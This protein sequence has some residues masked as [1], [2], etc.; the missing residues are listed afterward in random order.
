MHNSPPFGK[1]CLQKMSMGI[2][3]TPDMFQSIMME[4]LGNLEY[5][6]IYID[7]VLILKKEGETEENHLEKIETVLS[8]LQGAGQYLITSKR[9]QIYF[10]YVQL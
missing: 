2:A 3:F 10:Y 8:H 6:L 7:D 5:V 9:T 1:I 4:V